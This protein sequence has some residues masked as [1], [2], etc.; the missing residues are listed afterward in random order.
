MRELLAFLQDILQ[1]KHLTI[2]DGEPCVRKPEE[3][4]RGTR[5]TLT[6]KTFFGGGGFSPAFLTGQ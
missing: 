4:T 2:D 5:M 1:K 6:F 3:R